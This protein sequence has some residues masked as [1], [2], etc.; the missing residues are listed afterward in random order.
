VTEREEVGVE[1]L[2][3]QPEIIAWLGLSEAEMDAW[4]ERHES[5]DDDDQPARAA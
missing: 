2:Q 3:S 1:L 4:L 5:K